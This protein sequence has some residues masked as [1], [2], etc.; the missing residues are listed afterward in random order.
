MHDLFL[1]KSKVRSIHK[2]ETEQ[3]TLDR[4]EWRQDGSIKTINLRNLRSSGDILTIIAYLATVMT[5]GNRII[6]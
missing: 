1:G 2:I 5:D 6:K 3:L 4:V